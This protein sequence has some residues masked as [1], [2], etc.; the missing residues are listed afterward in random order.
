MFLPHIL[1]PHKNERNYIGS[2]LLLGKLPD[3]TPKEILLS[4]CLKIYPAKTSENR[5]G[6]GNSL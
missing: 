2:L 5:T 1:T 3:M 4:M 6:V